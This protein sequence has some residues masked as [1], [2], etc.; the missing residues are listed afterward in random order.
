MASAELVE[1]IGEQ[2]KKVTRYKDVELVRRPEWGTEL[3][4]EIAAQDIGVARSVA[5]DLSTMPLSHL[6]DQA[7][8]D[9]APHIHNVSTCLKQIDEF[10]M[11]G[12][13][14]Q[15]RDSIASSLKSRVEALLT[16]V[17]PWIA[18]LAYK[19]GDI[20]DSVKQTETALAEAK[21][22]LDAAESYAVEKREEIDKI[23]TLTREA[24]A[25]AG[26][27]T[28]T[29]EFDEEAKRL[30]SGSNKWL[31]AA[32]VLAILTSAAALASFFWPPLPDDADGWPTLRH[33][34]AK[35]SVI[36]VLFTGTIWCSRI[37]RAL[38]HQRSINRHRALSLKTFQAFVKA[39]D[40]PATRDAVLMAATKS[41]FGN[42]PTGFVDERGATQDT[43][44]NVLEIGK[45]ANKAMPTR[46]AGATQES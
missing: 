33:V 36:A 20:E 8:R 12:N 31:L 37:Y 26:V 5:A 21:A 3:T 15:N 23:V 40:D 39:T 32:T 24:S 6:T 16:S 27:A 1:Q 2:I 11:Q 46:R 14:E 9:I 44:V 28:F 29:H 25:S 17:S 43:S 19:R 18:Y 35:V 34:V 22:K 10:K 4:F 30:A 41:I 45:S 13:V 7:V 42:V 38:T